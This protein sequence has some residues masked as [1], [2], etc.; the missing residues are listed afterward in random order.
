LA[1]STAS[2]KVY[3]SEWEN[4]KRVISNE[5]RSILRAIFGMTDAE[6]FRD[7]DQGESP[8]VPDSEYLWTWPVASN[9]LGPS[10]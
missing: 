6:L 9:R 2:L 5:Y 3:V 7:E 10:T 8:A 1:A 4:G